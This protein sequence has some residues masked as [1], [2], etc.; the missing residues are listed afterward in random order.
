MAIRRCELITDK[1]SKELQAHGTLDFPCAGY[2]ESYD[3]EK[4]EAFAW[5]WHE[6]LELIFLV[7]GSIDLKTPSASLRLQ[8]G[9]CAVIN[10]N[11]LHSGEPNGSCHLYSLVFSPKLVA[12]NEA[13][14]FAR[15]YL[16]PL[17]SCP[18]FS[19]FLLSPWGKEPSVWFLEA[20]A[21]LANE[22][23]GFESII[24]ENLS[25]ICLLLC[26]C[27][28]DQ[29]NHNTAKESS[30]NQ[31]IRVMLAYIQDHFSEPISLSDIAKSADI[32][33]REC[34]RCFQKTIQ[35][36]PIQYLLK[37]RIMQGAQLLEARPSAAVSE[38][39]AFCGFD[40]PSNFTKL[41]KR[42]YHQTPREYRS[43]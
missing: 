14:V 26:N 4:G 2:D 31:R 41:F 39:A 15:R 12:G 18:S 30:D 33:E 19:C 22:D 23:F 10:S 43:V 16:S 36:S 28:K 13:F 8:K 24:R 34:L 7:D 29:L 1:S 27:F 17:L 32:G 11:I 42:F 37:Y 21:A 40:S 35:T 38:I 5:H 9:D 6:E 3:E 25:R 20:F